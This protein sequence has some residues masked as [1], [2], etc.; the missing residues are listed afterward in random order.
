MT[1][2]E[3]FDT[4]LNGVIK[5]GRKSVNQDGDCAYLSVEGMR[6]GVGHLVPED[7]ARSLDTFQSDTRIASILDRHQG[8]E[9]VPAWMVQNRCLVEDIQDAH[10]M[11]EAG[12]SFIDDF[13][14]RM[15]YVAQTRGLKI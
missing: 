1:P 13:V 10:D 3:I 6:C 8:R 14:A 2:Q 12:P 15:K 4:A 7:V 9:L 5:Q 11:A